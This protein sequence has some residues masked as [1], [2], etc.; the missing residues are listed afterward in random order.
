MWWYEQRAGGPH[1]RTLSNL[2]APAHLLRNNSAAITH[3]YSQ[4]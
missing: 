1:S 3:L 4:D 2:M